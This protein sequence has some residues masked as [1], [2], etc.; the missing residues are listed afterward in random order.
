MHRM[1]SW[2][3]PI[4]LTILSLTV[5]GCAGPRYDREKGSPQYHSQGHAYLPTNDPT[6]SRSDMSSQYA[7]AAAGIS[8]VLLGLNPEYYKKSYIGGR[9]TVQ[10]FPEDRMGAPCNNFMII[11]IDAA[12]GEEVSRKASSSAGEFAFPVAKDKHYLLKVVSEKFEISGDS[13]G[14]FVQG[15]D[16]LIT[17]SPS[18]K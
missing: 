18:R 5:F 2:K 7:A 9:C 17:L 15:E 11:L 1:R 16:V 12:S 8:A 4:G 6:Y 14:P 3:K 13:Q 10:T